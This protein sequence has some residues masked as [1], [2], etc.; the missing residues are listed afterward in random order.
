MSLK[1]TQERDSD[2]IAFFNSLGWFTALSVAIAIE[3]TGIVT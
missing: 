2:E 1:P 3:A